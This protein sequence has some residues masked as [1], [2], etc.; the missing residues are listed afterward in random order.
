MSNNSTCLLIDDD[1]DDQEI[2]EMALKSVNPSMV[3]MTAVDGVEA[4]E[5]LAGPEIL[6]PD[7]IFLDLNMPRM[8]GKDCLREIRKISRLKETP[9]IIYSTSGEQRDKQETKALG[10][11]FYLE[12]QSSINS[13]KK[14]LSDFF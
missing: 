12:K 2:F 10:A 3:V 8:D 6:Q 1:I 9:V 11:D 4:L 14:K 7:Y 5:K 13:L